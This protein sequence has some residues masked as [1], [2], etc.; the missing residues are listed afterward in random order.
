MAVRPREIGGP[1]RTIDFE[2]LGS[3]SWR[4][5]HLPPACSTCHGF[6]YVQGSSG[7]PGGSTGVEHHA[8]ARTDRARGGSTAG[9]WHSCPACLE[10]PGSSMPHTEWTTTRGKQS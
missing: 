10:H 5:P 8:R 6:G 3:S 1:M 4:P 2:R 7:E 9:G